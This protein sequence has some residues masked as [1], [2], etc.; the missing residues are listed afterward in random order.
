MAFPTSPK[1]KC[2]VSQVLAC[3]GV[4]DVMS[5]EDICQFVS[6]RMKIHGDLEV[7]ANEVIDTC[8]HKG[9][10]DNMS[11]I[12]IAFPGAPKVCQEAVKK[13]NELNEEIKQKVTGRT[14]VVASVP[15]QLFLLIHLTVS[16]SLLLPLYLPWLLLL[17]CL[18]QQLLGLLIA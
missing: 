15:V 2:V 7:I 17:L 10:R 14:I 8:L 11:I 12:I 9:S 1:K 16:T 4:W 3:D 18:E 6:H 5:N 13:E